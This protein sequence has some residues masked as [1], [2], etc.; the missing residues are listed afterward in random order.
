MRPCYKKPGAPMAKSAGFVYNAQVTN[1]ARLPIRVVSNQSPSVGYVFSALLLTHY[2]R[3]R[4][5]LTLT[6][7]PVFRLGYCPMCSPYHAGSGNQIRLALP[8][9]S[10]GPL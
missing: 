3:V 2:A 6:A 9:F 7:S 5:F 8:V 4:R 1:L 10:M